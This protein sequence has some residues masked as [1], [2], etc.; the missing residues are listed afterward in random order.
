M[1]IML[2]SVILFLGVSGSVFPVEKIAVVPLIDSVLAAHQRQFDA[3]SDMTFDAIFY[4][5]RTDKEGE[6]TEEKR[7]E[8]KIYLKKIDDTFHIH[9]KYV[10][11]YLDGVLQDR[12]ALVTEVDKKQEE[13]VKRGNRDFTYDLTIP[14][15]M[16]YTGMYDV[17]YKGIAKEKINGFTC[18]MLRADAREKNDTLLNCLYYV[19]TADY[20]LVRVDFSPAK[21]VSKLMFKLKELDMTINYKPYDS[22]IWIPDRFELLGKGKAAF[23]IG[24]YFQSEETYTNPVVN[25][26]LDD[27]L[28]DERIS[29]EEI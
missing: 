8:K 4:E 2:L 5:R 20:N 7:Y 13:R 9:Q 1:K 28:F 25:S 17:S 24:V 16:L 19:D 12:E 29:V 21:L 3:V 27:S 22:V 10:A 15:Q 11:L 14:L 26:G 6:V 23:F 18:Y